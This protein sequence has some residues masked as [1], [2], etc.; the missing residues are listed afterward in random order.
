M[1]RERV[2][3][4]DMTLQD[5]RLSRACLQ[6]TGRTAL[7]GHSQQVQ[8]SVDDFTSRWFTEA[9]RPMIVIFGPPARALVPIVN[10]CEA[11]GAAARLSYS[12]LRASREPRGR[13]DLSDIMCSDTGHA[14]SS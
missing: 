1:D 10:V 11:I 3:H 8:G 5:D 2:D 4:Q 7:I 9:S 13:A 14:I 6:A 12:Q